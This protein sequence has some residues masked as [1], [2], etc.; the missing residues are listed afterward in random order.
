[1]F[2]AVLMLVTL[3]YAAGRHLAG[4]LSSVSRSGSASR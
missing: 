1:M 4:R 2:V 3:G